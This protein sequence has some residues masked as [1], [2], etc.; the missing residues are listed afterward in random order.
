MA[1]AVSCMRRQI[2][3]FAKLCKNHKMKFKSIIHDDL[4]TML[5][6]V[7]SLES[8][9]MKNT[10]SITLIVCIEYGEILTRTSAYEIFLPLSSRFDCIFWFNKL[11]LRYGKNGTSFINLSF[12]I[13]WMLT[14]NKLI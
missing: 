14:V 3:D 1:Y 8:G 7:F 9:R 10:S 6:L 2:Y 12:T 4:T 11:F 13:F 5:F